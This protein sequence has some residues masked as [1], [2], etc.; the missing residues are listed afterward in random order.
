MY[1]IINNKQKG[2]VIERYLNADEALDFINKTL[3]QNYTEINFAIVST[4]NSPYRVVKAE[5]VNR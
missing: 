4:K 3:H 2:I 5:R 1:N